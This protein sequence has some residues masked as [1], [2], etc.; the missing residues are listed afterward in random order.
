MR[1]TI[2][3]HKNVL[4]RVTAAPFPACLMLAGI[5]EDSVQDSEQSR[6]GL[7]AEIPGKSGFNKS[8]RKQYRENDS[9]LLEH[10][11]QEGK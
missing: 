3:C 2:E 8:K 5:R 7:K 1:I 4:W 6:Q 9:P 10:R 11:A